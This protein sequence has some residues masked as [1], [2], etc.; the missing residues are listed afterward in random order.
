MTAII[1]LLQFVNLSA[2]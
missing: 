2:H 1:S